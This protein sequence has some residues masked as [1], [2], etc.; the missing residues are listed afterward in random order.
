SVTALRDASGDINGY[1]GIGYD[2]T[3]RKRMEQMKREFISTVSHE[4]RTPLTS[5]RGA[6]GLVAGGAT[7]TL[8]DKAREL[9]NIASNNCDRL[10]RLINDILDMEKIESGKMSFDMQVID[11]PAL[12]AETMAA[13]Q[14]YAALHKARIVVEGEFPMLQVMGDRDRLVQ[15]ITNLL[16]NAAKFTPAGGQVHVAL[17]KMGDRA[18]IMVRDEG[19]G[20]SAEFQSRL[21]QK[22]SQADSSDTRKKGGTGLGLSISKAI[23]EWHGGHIDYHTT[24]GKGA[25]FYIDLPLY[26]AAEEISTK[27]GPRILIVEDDSDIAKLLRMM[28]EQ[29]GYAADIAGSVAEARTRVAATHYAAMTLDLNLP[30][31]SGIRYLREL[32]S[33]PTTASLPVVVVSAIAKS[34]QQ[35]LGS[36]AVS[37]LDWLEKPIDELRLLKAVSHAVKNGP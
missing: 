16:S 7:G 35:Q 34:G 37:V 33:H 32:R 15:V 3:E 21:F 36:A 11:L 27:T 8:P 9:I 6:L 4:L 28:L 26:V 18:R 1:L 12:I 14:P 30:G 10:V 13:N 23:V 19:P 22:F 31:E 20:I 25:T 29:Q 24:A 17:Q 5:I 2:I